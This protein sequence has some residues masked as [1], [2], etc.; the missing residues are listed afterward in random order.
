MNAQ[1]VNDANAKASGRISTDEINKQLDLLANKYAKTAKIDGFRRGKV[2]ISVIKSRYKQNLIEESRQKSIDTFYANAIKE[3]GLEQKDVIGQPLIVKFEEN[4]NGIELEL[5]IGI[6]PNFTVDNALSCMPNFDLEE[7]T[8]KQVEERLAELAKSRAP[9]V[10]SSETTLKSGYVANI[11]FEGFLDNKPF[12]GGKA[13]GFNLS[14]GSKQFI[15]GFEDSI[16]GMNVGEEKMINVTFPKNYQSSNLAGQAVEFKVKLNS[17]KQRGEISIDDSFA[18]AILGDSEEN[19][20]EKLKEQIKKDLEQESKMKLY[21]E[22]LK[23]E[24]L[25]NISKAFHFDLPENILEQEMNVLF[26]NEISMLKPEEIEELKNNQEKSKALYEAQREKARTS[27]KVTF[28]IDKLAKQ[29]KINVNDNEVFQTLYYESMMSGYNPQ[30]VIENYRKNNLLPAVKMAIIEDRV[31]A[32]L[33]D[34]SK[35]LK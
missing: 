10:D 28:I 12:D 19:T 16:I 29:E 30:E 22:K 15:P 7:I 23:E 27:V 17:I 13:E 18:K 25:N 9:I 24:A 35:G 1:R 26:N 33:L 21:N 8:S 20:L 2:P 4:D 3:L 34:K 6:T 14:I 31:I 11:D 5:K 32:H